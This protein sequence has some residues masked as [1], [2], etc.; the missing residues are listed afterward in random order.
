M[1]LK[2]KKINFLGDSITEGVGTSCAEAIYHQVLKANAGLAEARNYGIS[3]TRIARQS[4]W[5][6]EGENERFDLDFQLR[7]CEM[8]PDCDAVVVFGGTNDFG[9]GD[10]PMGDFASR[11]PYTFYGACHLLM[12][13]LL[14]LFPDKLI[15]FMT[16]LHRCEEVHPGSAPESRLENYVN[17]LQEVAAYY[18]LPVLDL[19]RMSGIQPKVPIIK[20]KFCPDGLHPNDEG[21]KK[22]A[23]ILEGFLKAL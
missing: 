6:A 15:V 18:A 1:E 2:G 14:E 10:A 9:H 8:D 11:D 17:A 12:Q 22:I 3:G 4:T 20:E 16:P 21:H 5:K 19:F 7:A 13:K 23:A